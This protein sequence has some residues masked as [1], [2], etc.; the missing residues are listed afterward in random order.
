MASFELLA[1]IAHSPADCCEGL[2]VRWN[3]PQSK[4]QKDLEL[5]PRRV[6]AV[7]KHASNICFDM[8]AEWS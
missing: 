3:S 4:V 6:D 8:K 5:V 7:P 1:K 2:R